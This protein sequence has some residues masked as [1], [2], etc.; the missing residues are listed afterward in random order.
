MRGWAADHRVPEGPAGPTRVA[1]TTR[2]QQA[3]MPTPPP[4]PHA[5][6]PPDLSAVERRR[7]SLIWPAGPAS[8][9]GRAASADLPVEL[10]CGDADAGA[11]LRHQLDA[12]LAELEFADAPAALPAADPGPP[13]Q[14]FLDLMTHPSPPQLLLRRVKEWAKRGME[15]H[16]GDDAFPVPREVAGVLYYAAIAVALARL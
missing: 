8:R 3:L 15:Q 6:A 11:I 10:A 5:H 4:D 2:Q 7:L 12:P 1:A 9:G 16:E 13:L 14:S